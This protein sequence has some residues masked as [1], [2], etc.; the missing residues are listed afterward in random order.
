[1]AEEVLGIS[2]KRHDTS[3]RGCIIDHYLYAITGE[4]NRW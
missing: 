4:I 2:A 1:M 3:I